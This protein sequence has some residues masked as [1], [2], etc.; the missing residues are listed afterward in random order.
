M[1]SPLFLSILLSMVVLLLRRL[2]RS[3]RRGRRRSAR[4][5]QKKRTMPMNISVPPTRRTSQNG[6]MN[7]TVSMKGIVDVVP[8]Q[9]LQEAADPEGDEEARARR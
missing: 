4:M 5:F 1:K 3:L 7:F 6:C 9:A 2:G 8:L